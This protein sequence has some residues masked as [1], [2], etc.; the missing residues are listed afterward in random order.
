MFTSIQI[1]NYFAKINEKLNQF[2]DQYFNLIFNVKIR[3]ATF[4]DPKFNMKLYQI[5]L[6]QKVFLSEHLKLS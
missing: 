3:I 6:K 1:E 5:L 2:C 4:L